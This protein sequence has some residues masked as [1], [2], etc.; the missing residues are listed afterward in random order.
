M[1][2][3]YCNKQALKIGD[4]RWRCLPCKTEYDGA[5]VNIYGRYKERSY[6]FNIRNGPYTHP[7]RLMRGMML[8]YGYTPILDLPTR[9]DVTPSNVNEKLA[10]ILSLLVFS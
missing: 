3:H 6:F 2:C 1:N 7:I 5:Q 10:K 4:L 9:I 8:E